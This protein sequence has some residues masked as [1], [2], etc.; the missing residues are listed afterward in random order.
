MQL[1]APPEKV[2]LYQK[3]SND[4]LGGGYGNTLR[5]G[6]Y[7]PRKVIQTFWLCRTIV[8]AGI[9][10]GLVPKGP[11]SYGTVK[12]ISAPVIPMGMRI[13]GTDVHVIPK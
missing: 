10:M 6:Y 11:C 12:P 8:P 7:K 5:T 9:H 1:L 2:A 3:I 13:E 4:G